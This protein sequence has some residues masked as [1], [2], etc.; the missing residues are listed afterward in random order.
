M[1]SIKIDSNTILKQIQ[2]SIKELNLQYGDKILYLSNKCTAHNIWIY[3]TNMS[4]NN[5]LYFYKDINGLLEK[6]CKD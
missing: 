1:E 2:Y 3:F 6:F 5:R 4:L